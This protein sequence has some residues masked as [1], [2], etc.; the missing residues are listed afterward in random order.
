MKPFVLSCCSTLDLSPAHVAERDISYICFHYYLDDVP[1]AEA[2]PVMQGA[3]FVLDN[4]G[5]CIETQA[6]DFR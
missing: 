3:L 4:N 6:I 2:D 1:Y 5:K